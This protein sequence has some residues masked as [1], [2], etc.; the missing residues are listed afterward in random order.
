MWEQLDVFSLSLR[1]MSNLLR[2]DFNANLSE[3]KLESLFHLM[4]CLIRE[5]FRERELFQGLAICGI[6]ICELT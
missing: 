3:G 4:F 6:A 2:G 1:M 5:L